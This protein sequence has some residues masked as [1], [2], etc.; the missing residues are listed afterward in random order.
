M[1][2]AAGPSKFARALTWFAVALSIVLLALGIYWYG[3]S[4]EVQQPMWSDIFARAHGPMTFRFYLQ[5]IMAA[6]AA[7]HDGVNDARSGHKAFFWTAVWDKTQRTGRLREGLTSTARILLLGLC[8][9]TIYQFKVLDHFYPAEAVV[10]SLL[11]AV[12]PY[13]IL[14]W[15]VELVS[16][17]WFARH[18]PNSAT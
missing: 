4:L 16:R 14:R 3:L 18:S 10:I 9:D 13:F 8:M 7:L 2:A 1:S 12:I 15:I 11:L 17:R 6:I 5:P